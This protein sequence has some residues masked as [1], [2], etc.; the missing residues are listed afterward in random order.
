[1]ITPPKAV[2]SAPVQTPSKEMLPETAL[3]DLV[4]PDPVL[5]AASTA[6]GTTTRRTA[7]LRS[8]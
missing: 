1:L 2:A 8:N 4:A 5:D 6:S 3:V 7:P